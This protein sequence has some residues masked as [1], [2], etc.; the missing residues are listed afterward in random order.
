MST[1]SLV[2][3]NIS[4]LSKAFPNASNTIS[5][6]VTTLRNGEGTIAA[7]KT[8]LKGIGTVIKSHPIASYTASIVGVIATY[9]L[10][11]NWVKSWQENAEKQAQESK[12]VAD[13]AKEETNSLNEL[14]NKYKELA[15]ADRTNSETREEIKNIQ[16]EIAKLVGVQA[17]NLDLVNGKLDSQITKLQEIARIEASKD[18]TAYRKAA[19]DSKNVIDNSKLTDYLADSGNNGKNITFSKGFTV[20]SSTLSDE[21]VRKINDILNSKGL[22]S[23]IKKSALFLS[24]NY[25]DRIETLNTVIEYIENNIPDFSK[26]DTWNV[27]ATAKTRLEENLESAQSNYK[28]LVDNLLFT[29]DSNDITVN[30]LDDYKNLR[31]NLIN[32]ISSDESISEAI[33]SGLIDNEWIENQ[34]D[35]YL[36]KLNQFSDY[37]NEWYDKFASDTAKGAEDVKNKFRSSIENNTE[38]FD[39]PN[40]NS[41]KSSSLEFFNNPNLKFSVPKLSDEAQQEIND[42]NEWID[43]LSNSDKDIVY[44]ISTDFTS[45]NVEN[46]LNNF[47]DGGTV[48]LTLRPT[49]DN[50][51][52]KKAGWDVSSDGT[53]TVFTSTF[54]N[55]DGSVAIN[56]TPIVTDEKGNYKETLSPEALQEYAEGVIAGT[57][58]D[59]LKLQV[60]A[61]FTGGD[62]IDQAVNAAEKIH[63][64]QDYFYLKGD[65]SNF[66]LDDWK[67]AL[68]DYKVYAQE[69]G[70]SVGGAFETLITTKGDNDSSTFRDRV[71][72]YVDSISTLNNAFD[73]F[74]NSELGN[75]DIVKLI[76][77]FPQLAGRTDDLDVA[78]NELKDDLNNT[79]IAD[80]AEQFGKMETEEDIAKLKAFQEQLLELSEPS[81]AELKGALGLSDASNELSKSLSA[82][83]T[84]L[85]NTKESL[86]EQKAALQDTKDGYDNAID[87]IQ[88]LIDWTEKYIKQTKEDEISALEDKKNSIDKLV[89]KQKELL[90]AE[91]DEYEWNKEIADKQND[92]ASNTL[93]AAVA[94]LDDSS[95]GKKAAK[96]ANDTLDES[97]NDIKDSLYKHEL[98][99]REQA[100]DE[101]KEKSDEYYDKQIDSINE[102]L[103]DEVALYKAACNMI[104]TDSGEL[105]GKLLT[106][107]QTYTTTTEAEFNH[108]WNSAQSAMQEYN[109]ASVGTWD[110]LNELQHKSYDV[111]A[112]INDIS[113]SIETYE[114]RI[115]GVKQ[116]IEEL[117]D[118]AKNAADAISA[119]NM[120]VDDFNGYK[121]SYNGQTYYYPTTEDS[122]NSK[123]VASLN[124]LKQ[125]TNKD[126]KAKELL[127]Q[128]GWQSMVSTIQSGIK[129]YA[130]GTRN[131]NREF[132]RI[133]EEG[134]ETLF[135]KTAKGDFALLQ[136]GTQVFTK[137][138]TDVLNDVSSNP[139]SYLSD[140][141]KK[142][143]E[144]Q[145][146][147][148]LI[149]TN[150]L[151]EYFSLN[152]DDTTQFIGIE[153][154]KMIDKTFGD[155][156][157][158]F[159]KTINN[160]PNNVNKQTNITPSIQVNVQGDATQSTVKALQ[161]EADK[162]V[163]RATE[164]VMN[165]ALR[166]KN[167]I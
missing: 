155:T 131:S 44:K 38:N 47:S 90:Q 129:H 41:N 29:S 161:N 65:P 71:D 25:A 102:F 50:S 98:E 8:G 67:S 18:T 68:D 37:Y 138:Q 157:K 121:Y 1:A 36:S 149:P 96:E 125:M 92:V 70:K 114:S 45:A 127:R 136:P 62:A 122:E 126:S 7:F 84:E 160:V 72:E 5:N 152:K 53:A 133:N 142:K 86:E 103:N 20:D 144:E 159:S 57:R 163:K 73:K 94:N 30:S 74:R 153:H 10:F 31:N 115:D 88:N 162:I 101:L 139:D 117:A 83:Q 22:D 14:I 91:K 107:C 16:D 3:G 63:L 118:T 154:R 59:D 76:E 46:Q 9:K 35:G 27:L 147:M 108:M 113:A 32:E 148:P 75:E 164:N 61:E 34:V 112:A 55:S 134:Q 141:L 156:D 33:K 21:D 26:T 56:F 150:P 120:T 24:D 43:S 143:A 13:A 49:V 123:A 78:I 109:L 85:E 110:L 60:G 104:D 79:M 167:I 106:Y 58:E 48:D 165:I 77:N 12:E 137:K 89:D 82:E 39:F 2:G 158:M 11:T 97:R 52:L 124:I 64:L 15:K 4:S 69:V 146:N 145:A 17:D 99:I 95:A 166:N 130:K 140:F 19:I 81:I 132:A 105:Y 116:K 119:I 66:S 111:D 54:S 128:K 100:L 28:D 151:Y 40:L 87:S 135:A 42:F 51:E 23:V 93:S 80:F 6:F